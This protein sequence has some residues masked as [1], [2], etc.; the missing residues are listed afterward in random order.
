MYGIL[1][2]NLEMLAKFAAPVRVSSR[3]PVFVS[4]S[5]SLKRNVRQRSGQLWEVSAKLEPLSFTANHLFALLVEK[6]NTKTV[7]I[8]M[9]QN[10]GAKFNRK[11]VNM[12]TADG[13]VDDDAVFVTTGSFVPAGTFIKFSNHSKIYL[14]L[15]DC[16]AGG[17]VKIKPRLQ[18]A[19]SVTSVFWGDDVV[20]DVYLETQNTNGMLYQDGILMDNGELTLV[21]A[22]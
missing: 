16:D 22:I 11:E 7:K 20:V 2:D 19:L 6:G 3:S 8:T 12:V 15:N 10:Y 17:A 4:D 1:D 14:T 21:E 5:L 18:A 9:P 13:A